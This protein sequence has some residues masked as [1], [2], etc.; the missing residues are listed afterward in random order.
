MDERLRD[1]CINEAA[2]CRRFALLL[3]GAD[4]SS[5]ARDLEEMARR[6]DNLHAQRA[7][8]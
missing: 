4:V 8:A 5:I 6:F 1:F 2:R 7:G 3:G